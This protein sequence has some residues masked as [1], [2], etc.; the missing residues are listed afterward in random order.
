MPAGATRIAHDRRSCYVRTKWIYGSTMTAR[1]GVSDNAQRLHN[2]RN[3]TAEPMG[4]LRCALATATVVIPSER[5]VRGRLMVASV[6]ASSL[7]P[8]SLRTL[9]R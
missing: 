1:Q 4:R 6:G 2:R 8:W 5:P 3:A 9:E 7:E